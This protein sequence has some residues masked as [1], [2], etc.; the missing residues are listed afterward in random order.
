MTFEMIGRIWY[1]ESG[2]EEPSITSF[3][4][5]GVYKGQLEIYPISPFSISLEYFYVLRQHE[6]TIIRAS[7]LQG[8]LG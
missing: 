5:I 3:N 8:I 1:S 4:A 2:N 6:N 7:I